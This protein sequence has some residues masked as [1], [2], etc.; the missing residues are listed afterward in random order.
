[1]DQPA[2]ERSIP[3]P[4]P[5]IE[6]RT[7]VL[8]PGPWIQ[9]GYPNGFAFKRLSIRYPRLPAALR[10]L[11]IV[12]LSDFHARRGWWRAYDELIEL[13]NQSAD[14]VL[15]TGDLVDDKR[16]Y[17]PALPTI[18]R[19][20][21][22][23]RARLGVYIILG[24]H[25]GSLLSAHLPPLGVCYIDGKYVR[26]PVGS[27]G[28]ELIGLPGV[29]RHDLDPHSLINLPK[30]QP[31]TPRLI[32]SHYPDQVLLTRNLQPDLYLTG[33]THGGQ[34]CLPGGL[35]IL[36]HD[37]LPARLCT[38]IHRFADT[39]MVVNRGFGFSGPRVR[40]FCPAEVIQIV[41][42]DAAATSTDD[43]RNAP[44]PAGPPGG[45]PPASS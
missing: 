7:Q 27:D 23:F 37:S 34:I 28:V 5:P 40:L 42:E 43:G 20:L 17:R 26:L 36:R 18:Q 39:W 15:F 33:H 44:L 35:P 24:N 2:A 12:H 14:L 4:Q 32:L 3:T 29:H 19:L 41:L 8:R 31:D 11:R 30:R 22:G 10:G 38:G 25:D 1:M 13:V 6:L 9:L 21:S 16:D 45:N